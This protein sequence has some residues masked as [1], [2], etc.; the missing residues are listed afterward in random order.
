MHLKER[1]ENDGNVVRYHLTTGVFSICMATGDCTSR[2]VDRC[3][4]SAHLEHGNTPMAKHPAAGA[5]A[6]M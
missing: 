6:G 2:P 1:M 4:S 3:V 5:A